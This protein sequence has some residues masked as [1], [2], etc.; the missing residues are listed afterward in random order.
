MTVGE[1]ILALQQ[2]PADQ[3]VRI[4]DTEC[5]PCDVMRVRVLSAVEQLADVPRLARVHRGLTAES[6]VPQ[7]VIE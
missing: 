4:N 6:F 1:L 2:H 5:G 3:V 7:V